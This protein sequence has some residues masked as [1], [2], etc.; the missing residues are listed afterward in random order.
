MNKWT[1]SSWQLTLQK[2]VNYFLF[3]S[4]CGSCVPGFHRIR[5]L[6]LYALLHMYHLVC[7]CT[8]SHVFLP[9]LIHALMNSASVEMEMRK[10]LYRSL[11]VYTLTPTNPVL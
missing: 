7:F 8:L 11:S 3:M 9:V 5:K 10:R 2:V 6:P 4:E 1:A